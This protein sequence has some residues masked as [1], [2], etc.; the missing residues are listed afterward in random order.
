MPNSEVIGWPGRGSDPMGNTD[1]PIS[2]TG[3]PATGAVI[4]AGTGATGCGARTSAGEFTGAV[5]D[6]S[7]GGGGGGWAALAVGASTG[8]STSVGA[9]G[10]AGRNPEPPV[11]TSS[12]VRAVLAVRTVRALSA[13]VTDGRLRSLDDTSAVALLCWLPPA[14]SSRDPLP[15]TSLLGTLL[16]EL[17]PPR[18]PES[19]RRSES[20]EADP[21]CPGSAVAIAPGAMTS[22]NA[23]VAPATAVTTRFH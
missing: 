4:G 10:A 6:G 19:S 7:G 5:R 11:L 13:V 15:A 3:S 17:S 20:A 14:L 23:T 22:V 16:R 2:A 18:L 21:R 1:R 12:A 9:T 8:G